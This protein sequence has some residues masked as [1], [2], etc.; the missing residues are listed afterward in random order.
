M[1]TFMKCTILNGNGT[2]LQFRGGAK[3]CE[4]L[5]R[6]RRHL[7]TVMWFRLESLID[8]EFFSTVFPVLGIDGGH[9][10][11]LSGTPLTT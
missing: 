1:I 5:M 10:F 4:C 2:I 3:V 7:R 8:S 11:A 9:E 6:C